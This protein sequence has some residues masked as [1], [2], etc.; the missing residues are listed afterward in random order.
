MKLSGTKNSK[1]GKMLMQHNISIVVLHL[2]EKDWQS[3]LMEQTG[4]TKTMN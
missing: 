4:K 3:S 2:R 1:K